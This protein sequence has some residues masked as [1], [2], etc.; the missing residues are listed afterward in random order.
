MYKYDEFDKEQLST[1]FDGSFVFCNLYNK[2]QKVYQNEKYPFLKIQWFEEYTSGYQKCFVIISKM[3]GNF[4]LLYS[5]L[6]NQGAIEV[7]TQYE[8]FFILDH[9]SL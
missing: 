3:R 9:I 2:N 4:F 7:D 1:C 6:F 5:I 8:I